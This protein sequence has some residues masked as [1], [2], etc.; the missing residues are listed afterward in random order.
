MAILYR[1]KHL[2]CL[3]YTSTFLNVWKIRNNSKP[4]VVCVNLHSFVRSAASKQFSLQLQ[5]PFL[6]K[7]THTHTHTRT[8][9]STHHC[10]VTVIYKKTASDNN[11][12]SQ[13]VPIIQQINSRACTLTLLLFCDVTTTG[14]T[15]L[16]TDVSFLTSLANSSALMF[17]VVRTSRSHT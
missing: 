3:G 14:C 15:T 6:P 2:Q 1:Q 7:H 5:P 16:H 12:D 13:C 4:F 11:K 10:S 8:V 9:I 17:T